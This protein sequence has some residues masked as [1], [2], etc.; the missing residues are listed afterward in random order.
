MSYNLTGN[1]L[2]NELR[3]HGAATFG[4]EARKQIRLQRFVNNE[5]NETLR[6][7]VENDHRRIVTRSMKNEGRHLFFDQNGYILNK[8]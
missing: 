4:D 6:I 1:K 3:K 7:V 2:D 5:K 8:K